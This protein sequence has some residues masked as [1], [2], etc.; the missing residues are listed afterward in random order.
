MTAAVDERTTDI[1]P[2]DRRR[3]NLV[4]V[5]I[6]VGLLLAALDQTIVSTALPTI[7]G[8]LGGADHLSW[9]VSSYLLADTIATVLAGKFGDLFGRK[10]LFQAAAG[11]FVVASALCG[12]AGGMTWLIAWRAVQGFAAGCLMVTATALI[13]DIIPLRERGKYQGALG[14][15]FG[16]TTVL[17][18]LIGGLLTDHL[19]WRWTFY[20]NLPVGVA[21][22]VLAAF[23]MP[24]L[25]RG[26]HPNIDYLGIVFVS[27]GAA[28]L[29]LALSWGGTQYA[30]G[31]LTIIGMI[32]GSLVALVIFVLVERR[33]TEPILPLRLFSS[34]VFSVC[35]VLAFIVGF[36]M[37]GSMTFLPTYLQYVHGSSATESGLQTLP[38]VLGLLVMGIASGTVVG[39]T[40]RYKIFPVVGSV[41]M[42]VG[43]YLLSRLGTSTPY[44]QMALAMLVLGLGI[45]SSMQVLTI[46]VQSTVAYDDLGVATS[47]VTFFRTLGSSFGA[48]VFG[49]VYANVLSDR[50]PAAV[51][52]SPGVDPA[53]VSSP[54]ALHSYPADQI[55]PIVAAYAHA[56]HVVFLAAVPVPLVALVLALFLKEVP[57]RGTARGSASDVG[58]GF[59]MPEGDN[60]N[61]RLQIAIA[62]LL[63]RKGRTDLPLVRQRAGVS[64]GVAD[65]WAVG[66][67]YLRSRVGRPATVEEI[68]IRYRIPAEVLSPAFSDATRHG[69]LRASGDVLQLTELGQD[70]MAKFV[71][72]MRAWLAEEL[73]D[74]GTDDA[75]LAQALGDLATRF[76]EETPELAPAW[77]AQLGAGRPG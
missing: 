61:Q 59:G 56:V 71:A 65:Q 53:A 69:Y 3:M 42:A 16:V 20:I 38:M 74:W 40:G 62:R 43:L 60:S 64:L 4:F 70:E 2:L 5:T 1:D 25:K 46:V 35:G 27:L 29:T 10:F 24:S 9:V 28:G 32:I 52:A 75:E 6:L 51:A 57:L 49:T 17:G 22:I 63:Q 18:P 76:V 50:L 44:W 12:L 13:A 15:V 73:A 39:R 34:S 36:A 55:A 68:S 37:L 33:A 26:G 48:A 47:G 58:D 66:Q 77:A 30:W 31:S 72:A 54:E 7:V 19:S 67:V 14:A 41:V 23:T 8:D 45:G 21:V 11:V